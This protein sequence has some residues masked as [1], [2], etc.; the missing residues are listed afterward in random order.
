MSKN[1]PKNT[2]EN[3]RDENG[4]FTNGNNG[5]PKGATNKTTREVRE[6]ITTFLNDKAFEIPQIWNSLEDK[7]KATLY[8]HLCRLVLPRPTDNKDLSKNINLLNIDPLDDEN[9]SKRPIVQFSSDKDLT[10]NE[11]QNLIKKLQSDE[12]NNNEFIDLMKRMTIDD[13][14]ELIK[15]ESLTSEQVDKLIDKL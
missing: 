4:R 10:P 6:F 12:T 11:K 15:R 7:D 13:L 2:D 8:L 5:K 3:G 1:L 14:R 9:P